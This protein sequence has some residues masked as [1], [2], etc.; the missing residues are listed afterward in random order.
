EEELEQQA[1]RDHLTGAHNRRAF[2]TAM[3]KAIRQAERSDNTFSLL[4]FD[5]DRFKSVNDQHGH[6]T[7][8]VILKRL[9]T[10][11]SQT[12]RSTDLLARWGGEEFAV[13][14]QDTSASGASTFAERLRQQV[15]ETRLHGLAVTIS[16]GIAEYHRGESPDEMLARADGALYR[17]KRAG[18]NRVGVAD[19]S[20]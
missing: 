16:L 11:V 2:D 17:A 12:L 3:R 8:D 10:L 14:L 20:P 7:G 6:E 15:A 4:L 19:S 13:L 18:R 1:T 9:A 5:I